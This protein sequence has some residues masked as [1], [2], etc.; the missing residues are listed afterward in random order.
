MFK[1]LYKFRDLVKTGF[2]IWWIQCKI[3]EDKTLTRDHFT[4]MEQAKHA[5]DWTVKQTFLRHC[6]VIAN[7]IATSLL[8]HCK[9]HSYVIAAS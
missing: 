2:M 8:R 6:C 1:S 5:A 9:R 4:S 7:V 3:Y